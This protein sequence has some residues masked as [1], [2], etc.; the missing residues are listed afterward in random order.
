MRKF[1]TNHAYTCE[2]GEK[3]RE[4]HS[5]ESLGI[6]VEPTC[7]ST[8]T[9]LFACKVCGFEYNS[10]TKSLGHDSVVTVEATASTCIEHGLS[11]KKECTRCSAVTKK[12]TDLPLTPHTPDEDGYC[13]YCTTW[14]NYDGMKIYYDEHEN[15]E[16]IGVS[17]VADGEI[18]SDVLIIPKY[19]ND[20]SRVVKTIFF[21]DQKNI[22]KVIIPENFL[23][24]YTGYF[25]NCIN[26]EEIVIPQALDPI[27]TDCGYRFD[28][29]KHFKYCSIGFYGTYIPSDWW[30]SGVNAGFRFQITLPTHKYRRNGYIPRVMPSRNWGFSYN[31]AG[32]F[33]Y[34]QRFRA[35]IDDNISNNIKYNPEYIKYEI[36]N[37]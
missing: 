32:A 12:Q 1:T 16:Y 8:G 25:D 19:F 3:I 24:Y 6:I 27:S 2:C 13:T 18:Q 35:N 31:A 36:Q 17:I 7:T 11:E 23:R 22:K 28:M 15:G 4:N 9:E 37:F 5:F 34:G 10:P 30:N 29:I 26:L 14:T 33:V 21:E 20:G